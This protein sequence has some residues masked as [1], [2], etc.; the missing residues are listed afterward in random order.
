MRLTVSV[1]LPGA[2]GTTIVTGLLGKVSA[3]AAPAST[4]K[5]TASTTWITLGIGFPLGLLRHRRCN[6]ATDPTIHQSRRPLPAVVHK[7]RG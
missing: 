1:P 3:R 4:V 7:R 2:N 6:I 5:H